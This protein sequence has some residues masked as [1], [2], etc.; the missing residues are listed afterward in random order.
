[1]GAGSKLLRVPILSTWWPGLG[2]WV[3]IRWEGGRGQVD[4]LPGGRG[5]PWRRRKPPGGGGGGGVDSAF[6]WHNAECGV[7][8]AGAEQRENALPQGARPLEGEE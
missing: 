6:G 5:A 3:G 2:C 8:V 4:V 7:G 1:M